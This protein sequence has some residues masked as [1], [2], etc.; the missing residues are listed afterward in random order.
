LK[1]ADSLVMLG[2][3]RIVLQEKTA[4]LELDRMRQEYQEVLR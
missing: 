4:G 3:G 1:L 2:K